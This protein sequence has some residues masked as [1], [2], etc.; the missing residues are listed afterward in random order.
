MA[1]GDASKH[2]HQATVLARFVEVM[3]PVAMYTA[4][5]VSRCFRH[6]THTD[7]A[8]TTN[9]T[10]RNQKTLSPLGRKEG[11]GG[12]CREQKTA[13]AAKAEQRVREKPNGGD[14]GTRNSTNTVVRAPRETVADE[15]CPTLSLSPTSTS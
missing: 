6:V 4:Q 11:G 13:A 10:E 1:L 8:R 5:S 12:R 9:M 7:I 15:P 2:T 14:T 3:P